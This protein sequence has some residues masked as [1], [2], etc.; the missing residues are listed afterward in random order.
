MTELQWLIK[1]LTKQKLSAGMKDLFIERIGEVEASLVKVP[2][3]MPRPPI[4][5]QAP[6]MQ[7]AIEE[8]AYQTSTSTIP[9]VIAQTPQAV[10]ALQARENAIKQA[11]S[12]VPEPGRKSPR[13]F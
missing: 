11:T 3:V 7:R 8:M 6:S 13:K 10:A 5:T 9:D 1:M 2:A 12:G 4:G